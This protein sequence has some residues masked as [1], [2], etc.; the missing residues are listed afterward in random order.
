MAQRARLKLVELP[1]SVARVIELTN[2]NQQNWH[3]LI[4]QINLTGVTEQLALNS[5]FIAFDGDGFQLSLAS[6]M[7]T[8]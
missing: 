5:Q 6:S 2:I 7:R 8:C 1:K 4:E 3:C